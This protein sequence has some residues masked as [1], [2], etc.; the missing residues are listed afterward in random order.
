MIKV[1]VIDDSMAV[2]RG[3]SKLIS[4]IA[5][6]ELL[7]E[8]SNPIDAFEVF[9]KVG[10]PDLFILDIE[11]PKMDGITFLRKISEQRP[12]PVIICSTLV[13]QGS[14][15][16]IDA[17][18]YG[19]VDIIEKPKV[20]LEGFFSEYQDD[21]IEKIKAA[22]TANVSVKKSIDIPTNTYTKDSNVLVASQ[23]IVA[24][25]SSTGGVQAL[26]KV[27]LG[28]KKGHVGV[29]VT[30]HMPEGFTASFAKRLNQIAPYSYV[31]EAQNSYGS[32]QHR[33]YL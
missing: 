27:V 2:R 8:A 14:D 10:L 9:K 18:R 7:A 19:A 25:G 4:K 33:W 29:V 21:L 5:G 23:K 3:F 24:I 31:K 15:A 26:E 28:L 16:A 11:M 22:V 6:I 30:Q 12:I 20:N 1:M 13:A 17:L 32:L